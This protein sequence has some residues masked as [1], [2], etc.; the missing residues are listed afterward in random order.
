MLGRKR[1]GLA[2]IALGIAVAIYQFAPSLAESISQSFA[3]SSAETSTGVIIVDTSVVLTETMTS[4]VSADSMSVLV[5]ST[6]VT[7]SDG[8]DSESVEIKVRRI[9]PPEVTTTQG[10]TLR[11]PQTVRVDPRA[12]GVFLPGIYADSINSMMV[13]LSSDSLSID[14][15]TQGLVDSIDSENLKVSG[16]RSE[17]LVVSG[18]SQNVITLLNGTLGMR[19]YRNTGGV[20]NQ[21][22][23]LQFVD[24]SKPSLD[25]GFCDR[26]V[27]GNRRTITLLP[28]ALEQRISDGKIRL[29][30]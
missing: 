4:L 16:D 21:D 27:M 5:D 25:S 15:G 10:I 14:V 9:P 19:V 2:S 8:S 26:S 22:L 3:G 7:T 20:A 12:R 6:V 28:L 24:L 13:C 29:G 23:S 17:F 1:I 30:K 18:V 11:V